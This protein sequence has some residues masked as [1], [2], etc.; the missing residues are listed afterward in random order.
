[1][2]AIKVLAVSAAGLSA[3]VAVVAGR[4]WAQSRRTAS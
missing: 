4:P 2:K 3:V 1:M